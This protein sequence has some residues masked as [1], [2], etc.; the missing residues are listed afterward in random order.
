[1]PL[2][3]VVEGGST[4]PR[5]GQVR[6][7]FA[8]AC[9]IP[10]DP[11]PRKMRC[12]LSLFGRCPCSEGGLVDD[13]IMRRQ[14]RFKSGAGEPFRHLLMPGVEKTLFFVNRSFSFASI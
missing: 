6:K 9:A 5:K 7:Q 1:M 14:Q 10:F 11:S 13:S 4:P 12:D 3:I 8:N 2:A